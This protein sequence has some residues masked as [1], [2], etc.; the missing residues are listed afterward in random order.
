MD[1][2]YQEM[3]GPVAMLFKVSTLDDAITLANDSPFGLGSAIFTQDEAEMERAFNEI[4]AGAT[5]VNALTA[6]DPRLPFGGIKTSGYG[7][8]LAREGL[9][10]FCNIKTCVVA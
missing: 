2:Y 1:A 7:R 9:L 3:F 10:T 8:E 4:E 6:S 5:F